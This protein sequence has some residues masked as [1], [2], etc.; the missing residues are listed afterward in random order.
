MSKQEFNVLLFGYE[1]YSVICGIKE[2]IFKI[3]K[4]GT[5]TFCKRVP[6]L[7]YP[8]LS[9]E[10]YNGYG[11]ISCDFRNPAGKNIRAEFKR[12]KQDENAY[13]I[14]K[15][16]GLSCTKNDSGFCA[17]FIFNFKKIFLIF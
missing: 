1:I 15:Q 13:S 9:V 4:Q 5:K 16:H 12:K 2:R 11:L 10:I 7:C 6:Q 3:F 17:T 8:E 14:K